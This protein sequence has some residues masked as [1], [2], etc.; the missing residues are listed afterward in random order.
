LR[1]RKRKGVHN[2]LGK[3]ILSLNSRKITKQCAGCLWVEIKEER[4]QTKSEAVS[5]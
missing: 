3:N 1:R 5:W 2:S 4:N